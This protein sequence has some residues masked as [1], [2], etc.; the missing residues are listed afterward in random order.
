MR[1]VLSVWLGLLI[2]LAVLLPGRALAEDGLQRVV[3]VGWFDS[4]F[5][6]IDSYGRR[7]GYAYEYQRKIAA[8]TGWQYEYVE[9]NWVDLL[10]KLQRG[11]IDLLADV[12]YKEDRVGTMLL[13]NYAMGEEDY[14]IF[15]DPEK[16]TINPDDLT[17]LNGKRLAVYK[18][19]LQAQILKDWVVEHGLKLEI[20][21]FEE[22]WK[23]AD[24]LLKSGIIDGLVTSASYDQYVDHADPVARIGSSDYFFG[25]S[26]KRP[27]L[28]EE[29]DKAMSLILSQNIYYNRD[30]N[31][32]YMNNTGVRRFLTLDER[33]WLTAHGAIRVGYPDNMLPFCTQDGLGGGVR[34]L[35]HDYIQK[36]AGMKNSTIRFEA[37][38]YPTI[39]EAMMALQYGQV[40]CVFPVEFSD[41]ESEKQ[42]VLVTTPLVDAMIMAIVRQ[43]DSTSFSPDAQLR[44][45][46]LSGSPVIDAQIKD[47]FPQ[48]ELVYYASLDDCLHAIARGQADCLLMNN[49]RAGSMHEM[50]EEHQLTA[51]PTNKNIGM[52]FVLRPD[53][54][55]SST[56]FSNGS[57]RGCRVRR[58]MIR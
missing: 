21:E 50:L 51:V 7:T 25:I 24:N 27:E 15:I 47:K 20:L 16:S 37:V 46:V 11:E 52:A 56:R 1:K 30:L 48:W 3:R 42:Q 53:N 45:A 9:G 32:K 49:Y 58:S 2:V 8:Y 43:Q 41:Y 34:G 38:A 19:S 57:I 33:D 13:S 6:S 10:G 29:I 36:A 40:D 35:L 4:T 18:G 44:C 39:N 17:T 54:I 28:K 22:A 55:S 31:Q 5:N 23:D 12:S 26:T 14:Y